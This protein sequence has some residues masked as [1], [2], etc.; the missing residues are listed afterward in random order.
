M[1]PGAAL[2][3]WSALAAV[4]DAVPIV[5]SLTHR[6]GPLGTP[7]LGLTARTGQL[8][9]RPVGKAAGL[10]IATLRQRRAFPFPALIR[11]GRNTPTVRQ[12]ASATAVRIVAVHEFVA[13]VV[14]PVL[15]A[16]Y[17]ILK[18][19]NSW[20][21]IITVVIGHQARAGR[22]MAVSI[23]VGAGAAANVSAVHEFVTVIV[24]L[25]VTGRC[26]IFSGGNGLIGVV[27]IIIR[28]QARA[29]CVMTVG[30]R[31]G[32]RAPVQVTTVHELVAVIVLPV[33]TGRGIILRGGNGLIGVITIIIR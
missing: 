20:I 25:V 11:R 22:V 19:G 2:V 29:R 8:G 23:L 28:P 17:I 27:T 13:V 15:T 3:T 30:I 32:A 21:G 33:V 4:V 26:I 16:F 31:V 10:D 6:L 14:V 18:P 9:A 5:V 1:V 7:S 12:T 24:L